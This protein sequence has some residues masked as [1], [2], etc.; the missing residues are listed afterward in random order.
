MPKKAPYTQKFRTVWLEN[1]LCRDWIT[2]ETRDNTK[3]YCKFCKV[4]IRARWPDIKTH[5]ET[6]KHQLNS[7]AFSNIRQRKIEFTKVDNKVEIAVHRA[8]GRQALFIAEHCSILTSDHLVELCKGSFNDSI[9]AA[10]M[11]IKRSKCSALIN[12][13][14]GPHFRT[15]LRDDIGDQGYSLLLDESTD[16]SVTKYLGVAVKYY[17]QASKEVVSTFLNLQEL[18]ECNAHSLVEALKDTLNQFKLEKTNL[19]GLGT[20]NASVMVGINNGVYKKLKEEIPGLILIR[21]V[22][23]INSLR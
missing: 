12:N 16:V 7:D 14:L 4:V 22:L 9:T 11:K 15:I 23:I 8:E 17:S 19:I 5:S 2:P 20:D 21:L 3:A 13:V 6:R 10:N 18:K 1:E